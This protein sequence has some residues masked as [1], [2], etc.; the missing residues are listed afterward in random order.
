MRPQTIKCNDIRM[1]MWMN[2]LKLLL[3]YIVSTRHNIVWIPCA[4]FFIVLTLKWILNEYV[5]KMMLFPWHIELIHLDVQHI[6]WANLKMCTISF[7]FDVSSKWRYV[8]VAAVIYVLR[9]LFVVFIRVALNIVLC[10]NLWLM[11]KC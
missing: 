1:N 9:W 10:E 4:L 8:V 3:L 2:A 5:R 11:N 7:L 6:F